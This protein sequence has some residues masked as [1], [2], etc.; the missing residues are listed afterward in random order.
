MV[1]IFYSPVKIHRQKSYSQ[2]MS[3]GK[4]ITISHGCAPLL[5]IQNRTL[6]PYTH[7]QQNS[8]QQKIANVCIFSYVHV[9]YNNNKIKRGYQVKSGGLRMRKSSWEELEQGKGGREVKSNAIL[10]QLKAF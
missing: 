5:I 9:C 10:V 8:T 3:A 6:K 1:V 2:L 7:K 4:R